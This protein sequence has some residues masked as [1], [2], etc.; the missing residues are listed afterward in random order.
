M[1]SARTG[2]CGRRRP[3][4]SGRGRPATRRGAGTS[5]APARVGGGCPWR[6]SGG[7]RPRPPARRG[8]RAASASSAEPA[9]TSRASVQPGGE[10][11]RPRVGGTHR[12]QHGEERRCADAGEGLDAARAAPPRRRTARTHCHWT[13][14]RGA[15]E[16]VPARR[17]CRG[18]GR[19]SG[20]TAARSRCRGRLA[21][22]HLVEGPDA[23][24]VQQRVR[25]WRH[26]HGDRGRRQR[27]DGEVV[28]AVA[29]S[30]VAL[31]EHRSAEGRAGGQQVD[32][33]HRVAVPAGAVAEG[34]EGGRR[35]RRPGRCR[36]PD[37]RS[38]GLEAEG[39]LDDGA[40]EAHATARSPRT[41]RASPRA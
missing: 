23:E 27:V 25:R 2:R 5:P 38:D 11:Q 10:R 4:S 12:L 19:T 28:G 34:G 15:V 3:G 17:P 40:G 32:P 22:P 33:A 14:P 24:P 31:G 18:G 35:G 8:G 36:R 41:P 9:G 21:E 7:R 13:K 1:Q 26:R 39:G 20:S 37:G 30:E 6:G 29:G 16:P